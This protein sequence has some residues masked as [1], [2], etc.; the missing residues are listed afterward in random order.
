[1]WFMNILNALK[2]LID[3]RKRSKLIYE[4]EQT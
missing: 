1:M 3:K 4:N 2:V